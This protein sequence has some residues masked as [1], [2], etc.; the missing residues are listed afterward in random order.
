MA[1]ALAVVYPRLPPGVRAIVALFCGSLAVVAGIVDG[2]RHV[3]VDRLVGD[4][5]TAL[6]A[7]ARAW[8]SSSQCRGPLAVTATG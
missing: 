3:L 1:I 2:L 4:D 5:L 7:L 8:S 6:L